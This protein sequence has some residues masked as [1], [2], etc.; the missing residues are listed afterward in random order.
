MPAIYVWL[1]AIVLITAF[2][3]YSLEL[4]ERVKD[5]RGDAGPAILEFGKAFPMEAIRDLV[6]TEDQM[7]VFFRLYAGKVGCV[8]FH[9]RTMSC[10]LLR[11]GYVTVIPCDIP[12]TIEV[13]FL[14]ERPETIQF[15]FRNARQAAEVSLW[16]LGSFAASE[17]D[18]EILSPA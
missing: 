12:N 4:A 5:E 7:T 3:V 13:E 15:I 2:S 10:Q 6:T 1:L 14:N 16:L 11:P 17:H 18:P 9:G 8:R